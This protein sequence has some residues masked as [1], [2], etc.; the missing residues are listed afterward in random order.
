MK[1]ILFNKAY[2][3]YMNMKHDLE[4]MAQEF[5]VDKNDLYYGYDILLQLSLLN[6]IMLDNNIT[7]LEVEFLSKI[8][9][10][11]D[12]MKLLSKKTENKIG[13]SMIK[14]VDN[15]KKFIHSVNSSFQIDLVKFI[16]LFTSIDFST[17]EDYLNRL[18]GNIYLI[19]QKVLEVDGFDESENDA[20]KVLSETVFRKM[21]DL[22]SISFKSKNISVGQVQ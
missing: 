16:N 15:P 3:E 6:M 8:I 18:K 2:Y 12:L 19:C 20:Y 11:N 7:D 14:N 9:D 21:D 22:K 5:N 10:E 4:I 17:V 13:W 1:Q